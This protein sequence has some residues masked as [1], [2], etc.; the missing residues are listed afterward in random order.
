MRFGKTRKIVLVLG[1]IYFVQ[2][3]H[4]GLHASLFLSWFFFSFC[5]HFSLEIIKESI[6][7]VID[8]N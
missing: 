4:M 5:Y 7:Q 1:F 8:S 6:N 3:T 2:K